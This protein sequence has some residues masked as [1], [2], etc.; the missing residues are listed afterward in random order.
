M[1]S[2]PDEFSGPP[3]TA[4]KPL[5]RQDERALIRRANAGDQQ[6]KTALYRQWLPGIHA[7][8]EKKLGNE[9]DAE[10]L[11]QEIFAKV[12][13]HLSSFDER[14]RFSTW[15]WTI[16]WRELTAFRRRRRRHWDGCQLTEGPEFDLLPIVQREC[17]L[18]RLE[19]EWDAETR[20]LALLDQLELQDTEILT[21]RYGIA[22]VRRQ[23]L[24]E[25]G[26]VVGLSKE[27]VRQLQN[28]ALARAA[29]KP[30]RMTA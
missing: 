23:T 16:R 17:A 14:Y 26:D 25:V 22:G 2:N 8:C 19:R 21:K 3:R 10:E 15:L 30:R 1:V 6:A 24:E 18:A 5:S 29:A 27:R 11:C 13:Q 28:R 7:Y 12:F 9:H 20:I 4:R